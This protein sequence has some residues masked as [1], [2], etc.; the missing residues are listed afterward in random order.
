LNNGGAGV[1]TNYVEELVIQDCMSSYNN[2]RGDL[3]NLHSWAIGGIKFH[4][5]SNTSVSNFILESNKCPGLWTDLLCE[6]MVFDNLTLKSNWGPGLLPEISRNLEIKNSS[7][8]RNSEGIRI[9]SSHD[10]IVN[11]CNILG[12]GIQFS[13]YY[14]HRNFEDISWQNQLGMIWSKE[15][16]NWYINNSRI[17]AEDNSQLQ[18]ELEKWIPNWLQYSNHGFQPFFHFNKPAGYLTF[19][20]N[21]T[22]DN[23]IW[24]HPATDKP[25]FDENGNPLTFEEW[26]QYIAELITSVDRNE[27]EDIGLNISNYP[28]PFNSMTQFNYT[29]NMPQKVNLDIYSVTG[30]K[31]KT[32][33]SDFKFPGKYNVL[34]NG[35]NELDNIVS[36]GIYIY[37]LSAG[38]KRISRKCL[39]IK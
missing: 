8:I 25:F 6:D 28:N 31:V 26:K 19:F 15:P 33:V 35:K 24:V 30:E 9:H 38:E 10:V 34:W 5:T 39:L 17:E 22:I 14:D 32:L 3:G 23:N 1:I 37:S 16:T 11:N 27:E 29:L 36:S 7:I 4:H 13:L 12:N 20:A 21:S 18:A 2:W